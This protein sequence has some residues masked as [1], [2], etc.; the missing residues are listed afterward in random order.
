MNI[1]KWV[2]SGVMRDINEFINNRK[3]YPFS[4]KN[5]YRMF[6]VIV[7]TR[8]HTMNRA[9]VEAIDNITKYTHENRYG[10]PGW[11][12]NEGHLLNKNS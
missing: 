2:T 5:V 7:G 6:E 4:M 11:K 1:Q 12:T 9:I 10:L 3:N 8:E